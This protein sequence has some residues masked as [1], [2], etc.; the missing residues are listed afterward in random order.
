MRQIVID[1]DDKQQ[2]PVAILD[3]GLVALIDTGAYIPIWVGN[4]TVLKEN[5]GA[6]LI[7]KDVPSGILK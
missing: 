5:M 3:N 1:L 7:K 2:R 4:E 6:A